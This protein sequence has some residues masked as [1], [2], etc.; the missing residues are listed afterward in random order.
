MKVS[1]GGAG[2]WGFCKA[3]VKG[4]QSR[5]KVRVK[6]SV[7]VSRCR[8]TCLHVTRTI[9]QVSSRSL[10]LRGSGS[11]SLGALG[12]ANSCLCFVIVGGSGGG[13]LLFLLFGFSGGV[14][15][16]WGRRWKQVTNQAAAFWVADS[17][18]SRV[19]NNQ[20]KNEGSCCLVAFQCLL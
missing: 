13:G 17:I 8:W 12:E 19:N 4:V 3:L 7:S 20:N 11:N 6:D 9:R 14:S 16:G 5:A 18:S 1:G 15:F 10:G 2:R